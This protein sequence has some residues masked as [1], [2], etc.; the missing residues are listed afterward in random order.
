MRGKITKSM[1][2]IALIS[3]VLYM[4][5]GTLMIFG[6]YIYQAQ[7]DLKGESKFVAGSLAQAD[8][9][10]AYLRAVD[11]NPEYGG[12]MSLIDPAG[13]VLYDTFMGEGITFMDDADRPE[14][15]EARD[16]GAGQSVRYSQTQSAIMIFHSTLLP[17][18]N[19]LRLAT[20]ITAIWAAVL[21][22]L[23]ISLIAVAIVFVL[24]II[25]SR[26]MTRQIVRPINAINLD[27]PLDSVA[28]DELVPLLARLDRQKQQIAT[29]LQESEEQR[30]RFI[31]VVDHMQEG[32]LMLDAEQHVLVVN[33]SALHMLDADS[34]I[35]GK[36][37]LNCCDSPAMRGL[38]LR[39]S[40][41]KYCDAIYSPT[42]KDKEYFIMCNPVKEGGTLF[43]YV[44][45]ILDITFA[46]ETER[47]R[48][49]FSSNVSHELKTPLTSISGYA[50]IMM[51]GLAQPEDMT[52]FAERIYQESA[53]LKNM[54]SGI[55]TLSK[56]DDSGDALPFE[57][58]DL[59]ALAKEETQH[60]QKLAQENEVLLSCE[61]ERAVLRAIPHLL[62]E[63]VANLVE[64]AIRYNRP[65]G[66]VVVSVHKQGDAVTLTVADTGIGIPPDEQA[67]VF[68]RFFRTEKSRSTN[69][70]GTGLGLAIVKH[71]ARLHNAD[72]ELISEEGVGTTIRLRFQVLAPAQSVSV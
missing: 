62:R 48:R 54:V 26:K 39:A 59:Y 21:R 3:I 17:D 68:E 15:Q 61:G 49:E 16:T 65:G 27:Q 71:S 70:G 23:P 4:L 13:N 2:T 53:R 8:D 25:I 10:A 45:V 32:M 41:E 33:K 31:T 36:P 52:L 72:V 50:E 38:M 12:R 47:M 37:V 58:V 40:G 35:I 6:L 57:D 11:P 69:L 22:L 24:T 20:P 67:R 30:K 19:V 66:S 9:P 18:G 56:L 63:T 42:H 43:G 1:L 60:Y 14:L 28:Y 29:Q 46:R 55:I 34:S 64:N 44:L 7:D 5:L 51:N